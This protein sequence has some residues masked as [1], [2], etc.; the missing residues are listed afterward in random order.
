MNEFS[1]IAF[2]ET[3]LIDASGFM[4]LLL[5]FVLNM[6]V[7]LAIIRFSIIRRVA[8]EIIFSRLHLSVSVFS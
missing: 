6:G 3:P 2:M 5:R 4:E 7:V 1:E 8:V